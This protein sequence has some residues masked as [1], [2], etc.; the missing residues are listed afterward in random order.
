MIEVIFTFVI[1]FLFFKLL[2][3]LWNKGKNLIKR[4]KGE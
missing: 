3:W 1:S 2:N 4:K